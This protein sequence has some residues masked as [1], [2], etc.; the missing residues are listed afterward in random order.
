MLGFWR[1]RKSDDPWNYYYELRL[2]DPTQTNA[3]GRP[4]QIIVIGLLLSGL[5]SKVRQTSQLGS[6]IVEIMDADRRH[7]FLGGWTNY[8]GYDSCCSLCGGAFGID[9]CERCKRPVNY[10]GSR[11]I[12]EISVPPIV[13]DWLAT[14]GHVFTG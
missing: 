4:R 5:R 3:S 11:E 1:K 13:R 6:M 2:F 8:F 14:R 9:H 7:A 10:D 12:T